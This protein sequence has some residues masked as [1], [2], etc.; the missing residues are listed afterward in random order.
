MRGGD[1]ETDIRLMALYVLYEEAVAASRRRPE[2]QN[3]ANLR[4]MR[5]V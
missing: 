1:A 3:G 2:R 5:V 4:W